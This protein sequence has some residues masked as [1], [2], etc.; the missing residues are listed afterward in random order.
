LMV[1]YSQ[2]MG[3]VEAQTLKRKLKDAGVKRGWFA[4]LNNMIIA[5][6]RSKGE[7]ESILGE[8]LDEAKRKHV[9][10]FNLK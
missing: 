2:A 1:Y 5:G 3:K 8:I 4:T 6:G 10:I 7:V 9:C